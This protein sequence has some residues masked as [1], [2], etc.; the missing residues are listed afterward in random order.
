[1]RETYRTRALVLTQYPRGDDH[2]TVRLLAENLG[3]LFATAQSARRAKAKLAPALQTL[4]YTDVSLV[5]GRGVWR[6]TGGVLEENFY[7]TLKEKP[8]ARLAAARVAKLVDRLPLGDAPTSVIEVFEILL[9]C[10]SAL[11]AS[12]DSDAETVE[13]IGVYRLLVLLG[14][15]AEDVFAEGVR[16]EYGPD[17][18]SLA[19]EKQHTLTVCIN[20]GIR[21]ATG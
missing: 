6:V 13:R 16:G 5:R 10:L 4:S 7:Q 3:V 9:T 1:M 12:T 21:S 20:E 14:Y 2:L 8:R 17:L 15:A 19:R 18:Y 11:V